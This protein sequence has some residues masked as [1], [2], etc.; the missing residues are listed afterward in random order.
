MII[1][2]IV[3]VTFAGL[4]FIPIDRID[5]LRHRRGCWHPVRTLPTHCQGHRPCHRA[6]C[7]A[8]TRSLYACGWRS[9]IH[10]RRLINMVACRRWCTEVRSCNRRRPARWSNKSALF[11]HHAVHR[12]RWPTGLIGGS[13]ITCDLLRAVLVLGLLWV[14]PLGHVWLA[15]VIIALMEHILVSSTPPRRLRSPTWSTRLS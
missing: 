9:L 12:A 7:C 2:D 11:L 8:R 5:L 6:T 10:G 1:W 14:A 3:V 13:I 4:F 15:F